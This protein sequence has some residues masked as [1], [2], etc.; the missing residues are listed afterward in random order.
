MRKLLDPDRTN[1]WLLIREKMMESESL[2]IREAPLLHLLKLIIQHILQD[3][4]ETN[5]LR[6]KMIQLLSYKG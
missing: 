4:W 2:S 6:K 3:L 5:N 1:Q